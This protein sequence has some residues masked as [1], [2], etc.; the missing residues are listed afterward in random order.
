MIIKMKIN[1]ENILY[2]IKETQKKLEKNW[3]SREKT[4][5]KQILWG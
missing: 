5:N 1:L 3:V 2:K 4:E